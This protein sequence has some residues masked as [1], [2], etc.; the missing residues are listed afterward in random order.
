MNRILIK[1]AKIVNEGSIFDGDVLIENDLI[2]E[3]ADSISLKT[4]DCIVIDAEGSYL[5]PGAIDDQVHFRE[6]GL[7]HKGDIES[8]SRAA[9]AGGITS[10]IEQPN[11]VP[12]AVTQEILEDKYQ[13]A[14]QKSFANYSFMMGA[15]NDNLEEVL[16]TNPKNVA[17]IK[18]F[19]GSSTGN[20]LVDREETLEKIF[21]STPM[22]IAVHCEDETTIQNNLAEFKEKYGDDIP[23]T[24][25][26]L[27]RSAEACY[28]SSSKAVALAKKTG[29]RLHI[30]HLSTAKEMELF[31][32]KI[33]LEDKK[34]TAE[35]CVHHLWFTDEDYKTKGNFIKWNPAVKTE[36]D[37]KV[38][39]EALNDGRID[40]IATD[41]APHT[42]E[43]KAQSYL[44]APSGGPLVQHA[45][46]A[47]FEAHHQGKISV[48][49]IVEKM[50]HNPAKIFKIEKR[51]FIKEGYF[52]DLVIV[53][54]SKPWSVN[55]DNI[56]YKCGWSPFEG[57]TFKSRITHTFVNGE[58]VYNN[59][60]VKDIRAGK[61][62]L[63]DR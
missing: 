39:W 51:G 56:L 49:K 13:I 31:T 23:V 60:K 57:T 47:M 27:I 36:S 50:C 21:S 28:L 48:E 15:T 19:L 20:M 42:K 18:I 62:L 30:F 8:E 38:L 40:V 25:H 29:A 53:N 43:E 37:R 7:T 46:V 44:K 61:R 63:F 14:A 24:A 5:M 6:P 3:V 11:T 33:P 52:A 26:N 58:M 9:V 22:L 4:S 59:F 12:N 16:K 55:T 45:V 32:N 34:I 10:F 35:V 54:P 17:G 1:N 2:V 41:H